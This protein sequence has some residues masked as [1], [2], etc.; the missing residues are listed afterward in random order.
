VDSLK[1]F[2]S[3]VEKASELGLKLRA[4]PSSSSEFGPGEHKRNGH[5]FKNFYIDDPS[6]TLVE[7][8]VFI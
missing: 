8:M 6:G 3:I 7:L 1:K 5:A 4:G 2:E